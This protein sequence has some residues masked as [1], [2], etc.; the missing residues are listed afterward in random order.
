MSKITKLISILLMVSSSLMIASGLARIEL[1][2][3]SNIMTGRLSDIFITTGLYSAIL[4]SVV[5]IGSVLMFAAIKLGR[6]II[7]AATAL[8]LVLKIIMVLTGGE[9]LNTAIDRLISFES[10]AIVFIFWHLL[11]PSIRQEFAQEEIVRSSGAIDGLIQEAKKLSSKRI[12]HG[13]MILSFGIL[14]LASPNIGSSD[15][16]KMLMSIIPRSFI[17]IAGLKPHILNGALLSL[18]GLLVLSRKFWYLVVLLVLFFTYNTATILGFGIIISLEAERFSLMRFLIYLC[19][20]LFS[21]AALEY[22]TSLHSRLDF[23]RY[24]Y[25]KLKV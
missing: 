11:R 12:I 15:F 5:F 9:S 3:L 10:L 6:Y 17:P 23:K 16:I 2:S 4:G 14:H 18:L 19:P 20:F 13:M 1:I 24:R 21:V 25:K 8:Y 22:L 7:L